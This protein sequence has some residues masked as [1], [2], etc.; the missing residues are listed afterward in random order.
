MSYNEQRELEILPGEIELLENEIAE[1]NE[2]LADPECYQERGIQ[3]LTDE[4]DRLETLYNT[5]ADRYLELLELQEELEG[6]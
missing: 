3:K 4:L 2:C 1:L 5:K 6:A